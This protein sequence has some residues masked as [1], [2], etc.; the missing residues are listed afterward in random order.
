MKFM[1]L[2]AL[3]AIIAAAFA[4]PAPAPVPQLGGG[5]GDEL[6]GLLGLGGD[7]QDPGLGD[8]DEAADGGSPIETFDAGNWDGIADG[9]DLGGAGIQIIRRR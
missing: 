5:G 3:L 4:A 8:L 2:F 6:D 9:G 1:G 7:D